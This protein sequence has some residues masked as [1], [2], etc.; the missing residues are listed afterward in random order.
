MN[1]TPEEMVEQNTLL[2][3]SVDAACMYV[4]EGKDLPKQPHKKVKKVPDLE[5]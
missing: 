3:L 5:V 1:K 2:G 4:G